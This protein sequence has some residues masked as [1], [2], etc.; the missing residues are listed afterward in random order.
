MARVAP[1]SHSSA[2]TRSL[3]RPQP[4][5]RRRCAVPDVRPRSGWCGQDVPPPVV[6]ASARARGASVVHLDCRSLEPTDRGVLAALASE[7]GTRVHTVD[8]I[9]RRLG[10]LP[11]LAVILLD[12]YEVLRLVDTGLRQ[13]LVLQPAGQRLIVAGRE[14]PVAAW[15]TSADA[16]GLVDRIPLE[17]LRP[18]DAIH[19]FVSLGIPEPRAERLNRV[20]HGHPLGD[21]AGGVGR[22]WPRRSSGSTTSR[23]RPSSMN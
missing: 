14:P 18:D 16:A 15:L 12:H 19:L 7:L 5:P 3:S 22:G 13:A 6:P 4:S 20:I 10:Q 2:A 21:P 1:P 11:G 9:S 8:A 17:P 23:H